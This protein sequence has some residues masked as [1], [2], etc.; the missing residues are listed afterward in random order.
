M[1]IIDTL[2]MLQ[3]ADEALARALNLDYPSTLNRDAANEIESLRAKLAAAEKDAERYAWLNDRVAA[4]TGFQLTV[5]KVTT[6]GL[7]PWSGDNLR[8][9]VDAAIAK[10]KE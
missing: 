8:Q 3:K 1:D 4:N 9:A 6:R 5:C 7:E 10:E 2:R